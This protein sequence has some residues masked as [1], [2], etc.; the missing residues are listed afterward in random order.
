MP[1]SRGAGG[2]RGWLGALALAAA[3]LPALAQDAKAPEWLA[4]CWRGEAGSAAEGAYEIWTRPQ[5]GQMLGLSQTVR[6]NRRFFEYMRIEARDGKLLFIPQPNGKPPVE[7][8][9]EATE[10]TRA[11]FANPGHDFP[12]Y[13]DYARNGEQLVAL[14]SAAAPGAA[15]DGAGKRQRFAFRRVDCDA[16]LP[17]R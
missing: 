14:L 10:P 12:K 17:A 9:A 4:G 2:S 6:G 3:S 11:L 8:A 1:R 16:V 5:A 7:F 13:V 15:S